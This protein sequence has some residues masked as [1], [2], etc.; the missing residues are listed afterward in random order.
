[1]NAEPFAMITFVS[2]STNINN[3]HL[4]QY[5]KVLQMV[6]R[7]LWFNIKGLF[8]PKKNCRKICHI[9]FNGYGR[10]NALNYSQ[11]GF[12]VDPDNDILHLS[13]IGYVRIKIYRKIEGVI[14][15]VIIK[16][17]Y[18][19]LFAIVQAEQEPHLLLEIE[20][21]VDQDLGLTSFVAD[22]VGNEIDNPRCAGQS[23][24]K[25]ARLQRRLGRAARDLIIISPSRI[26]S[27]S[28]ISESTA[29]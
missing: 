17:E 12:K 5:S 23:A 3:W 28:R 13:K 25:L 8:A 20:E 15:A 9:R 2:S 19:R 11:S 16:R 27:P 22:F 10:H 26:K 4:C 18:K 6:N 29:C 21:V 1:M 7:T 24:D 14:K